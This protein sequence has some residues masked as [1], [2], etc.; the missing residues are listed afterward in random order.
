MK[1]SVLGCGRWGTFIAWYLSNHNHSVVQWGRPDSKSFLA[2]KDNRFNEYVK[3]NE[4]VELNSDLKYAVDHAEIIIISISSQ[5]LR[6]LALKLSKFD[7]SAKKIVL[8]MKGIEV[9]TGKR[10][11]EVVVEC[12]IAQDSVAVWV[13]P[14]HI[15]A[16]FCIYCILL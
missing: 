12:G 16:F 8:C 9:D 2:L 15:Q 4:N 5:S 10:L 11:S 3:L 13:G 7:L 1:V 6:E 14:G